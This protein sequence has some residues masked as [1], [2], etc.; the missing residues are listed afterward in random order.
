MAEGFAFA[1]KQLSKGG[2]PAK[3]RDRLREEYQ[4]KY[5]NI[6]DEEL[7][8]KAKDEMVYCMGYT[9]HTYALLPLYRFWLVGWLT[10]GL[11]LDVESRESAAERGRGCRQRCY[12]CDGDLEQAKQASSPLEPIV[13]RLSFT[14]SF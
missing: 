12:E 10:S 4:K 6:S 11:C 3:I 1:M 13:E 5:G 2:G 7:S 8:M 9:A 14:L